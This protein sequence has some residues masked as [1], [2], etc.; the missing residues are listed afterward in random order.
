[1]QQ[2]KQ[3]CFTNKILGKEKVLR[4][5]LFTLKTKQVLER[6]PYDALTVSENVL[7][8]L[9]LQENKK[10]ATSAAAARLTVTCPIF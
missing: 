9:W 4:R 2:Q 6:T 8:A 7:E 10:E 1:M 3:I 5:N